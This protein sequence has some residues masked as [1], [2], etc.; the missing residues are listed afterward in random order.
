MAHQRVRL[1]EQI[2]NLR[3]NI[4]RTEAR[5]AQMTAE[6]IARGVCPCCVDASYGGLHGEY[7]ALREKNNRRE[8]WLEAALRKVDGHA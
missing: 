5:L 6:A 4:E 3:R 1:S 8:K 7:H 2:A